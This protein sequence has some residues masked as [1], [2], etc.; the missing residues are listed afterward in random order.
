MF[1]PETSSICD[2]Q[3][4]GNRKKPSQRSKEPLAIAVCVYDRMIWEGRPAP[5]NK[6]AFAFPQLPKP[7]LLTSGYNC[8]K[9]IQRLTG[10]P[11]VAIPVS[12]EFPHKSLRTLRARRSVPFWTATITSMATWACAP[13]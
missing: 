11:R 6:W 4:L 10:L 7:L 5:L 13:D 9:D 3:K 12:A 8:I 2:L 1:S